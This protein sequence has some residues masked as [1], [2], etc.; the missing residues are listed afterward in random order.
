[1]SLG[2][3]YGVYI[4]HLVLFARI[5]DNHSDVIYTFEIMFLTSMTK[6]VQREPSE[7]CK[8]HMMGPKTCHHPKKKEEKEEKKRK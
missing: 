2:P 4:S 7:K 6:Y 5:C 1:M 8:H 3:S